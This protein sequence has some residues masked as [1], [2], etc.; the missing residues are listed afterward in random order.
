[1]NKYLEQMNSIEPLKC[2]ISTAPMFDKN[3][4]LMSQTQLKN[5]NEGTL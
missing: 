4:A 1:V 2:W 5:Q 3:R